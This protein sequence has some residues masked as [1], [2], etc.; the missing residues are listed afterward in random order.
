MTVEFLGMKAGANSCST[1]LGQIRFKNGTHA[2]YIQSLEFR[3]DNKEG[4]RQCF[5]KIADLTNV[6]AAVVA[7]EKLVAKL[8]DMGEELAAYWMED[9]WTGPK[10]G[11]Y[12]LAFSKGPGGR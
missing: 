4:F 10:E 6:N 12:P 7:Q 8:Q 11:Q 1:N 2:K 9:E 5:K 3:E